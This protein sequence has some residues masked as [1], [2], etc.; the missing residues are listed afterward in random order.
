[1]AGFKP[2]V[3]VMITIYGNFAAIFGGKMAFF[4]KSLGYE[5]F[6]KAEFCF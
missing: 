4:L 2:G 6:Q 5:V 1:V 3:N